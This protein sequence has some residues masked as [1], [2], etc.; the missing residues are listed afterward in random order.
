[1]SWLTS[2]DVAG[3]TAHFRVIVFYRPLIAWRCATC[4]CCATFRNPTLPMTLGK[5]ILCAAV[6]VQLVGCASHPHLLPIADAH[7]VLP[8]FLRQE[9]AK[10][11]TRD[12]IPDVVQLVREHKDRLFLA[13]AKSKEHC[14]LPAAARHAGA[15]LDGL[16]QSKRNKH[17]RQAPWRRDIRSRD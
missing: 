3:E 8:A 6:L 1:M 5:L 13:S 2:H 16:P 4:L 15:W 9:P 17:R 11:I 10:P 7:S 12:P 14:R